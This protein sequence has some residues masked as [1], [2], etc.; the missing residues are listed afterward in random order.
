MKVAVTGATGF[1]GRHVLRELARRAGVEVTASSRHAAPADAL[2]GGV[3]HVALDLATPSP[4]DYD[5]LGRPDVLVHL[6]WSGLPNYR[7][8]HHFETELPRQYQFLRSLLQAGLPGLFVAG[9]CYEYGMRCGEM[10]ESLPAS[11]ANPYAF[12]KA[13][14]LRQ[15]E[16]LRNT[17]HFHLTW[18]RLFYMHGEGQAKTSLFPQLTAAAK[19]GDASFKMSGGEQL[20]DYLPVVE[21]A[22]CIVE[23]A[24]QH[25]DAGIVNVCSGRPTSVRSLAERIVAEFGSNMALDLGQFPYPDYEPMAFW[26]SR[27]KLDLLLGSGATAAQGSGSP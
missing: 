27:K 9:T 7:S 21:V 12:A 17:T 5:K 11:P 20:R 23:L 8:L 18:G 25:P 26:G 1:V 15:L 4:D 6:A 14:L 24:L 2:P 3:R 19:R 10:H 13:A 16:F 22:H